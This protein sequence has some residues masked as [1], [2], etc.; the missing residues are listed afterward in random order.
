MK[1]CICG[2]EIENKTESETAKKL[3]LKTMDYYGNDPTPV[4]TGKDRCC[5]SCNAK[6]VTPLRDLWT[7][8]DKEEKTLAKEKWQNMTFR[9]LN[10]FATHWENAKNREMS[11]AVYESLQESLH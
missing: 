5:D 8:L 9:Q 1:C 6:I 3:G 2:N 4:R 11:P 7:H 10:M